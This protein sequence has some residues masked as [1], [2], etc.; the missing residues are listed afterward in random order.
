MKII[1][2]VKNWTLPIAMLSGVLIY[3]AFANL[4]FLQPTKPT[5]HAIDRVLTPMLI[6]V[7]L[8]LT[9]CKVS[10][11]EFRF[12]TWHFILL[13]IQLVGSVAVY[14]LLSPIDAILAQGAMVCFICPTATAAAVI[15]SKLGGSAETLITYTMLV[16][17]LCAIFVPLVFPLIYSSNNNGFFCSFMLILSKVFPLLICPFLLA[18]ILRYTFSVAHTWLREHASMAFYIW[19]VALSLVMGKTAK[20]IVDDS[21]NISLVFWLAT[22]SLIICSLQFFIGKNIGGHYGDRISGGQAIGQKNTVLAIWMAYTYLNPISSVAPGA[23]VLWQNII[24]SWQLWK[25]R[26]NDKLQQQL[27][28]NS[29]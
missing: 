19:A 23:Y 22:I 29:Q 2:F 5:V 7:Q 13:A 17:I 18:Q 12:R 4:Q 21:D 14:L 8:L 15:T 24:N 10:P 6:F 26:K 9:F 1:T 16:N 3:L 11:R 20:A 27:T 25:K 28:A